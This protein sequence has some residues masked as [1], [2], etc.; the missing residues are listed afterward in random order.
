MLAW[1]PCAAADPNGPDVPA[2]PDGSGA[3]ASPAAPMAPGA[4]GPGADTPPA[5][6]PAGPNAGTLMLSDLGVNSTIKFNGKHN[7]RIATISFPVPKGLAPTSL[8]ATVELPIPMRWGSLTAAQSGRTISRVPLPVEDRGP[9]VIPLNGVDINGGW[10]TVTL[11]MIAD[12]SQDNYC[13]DPLS[14]ARLTNSSVTFSGT[15]LPPATVADF[16]TPGLR[17]LTIAVPPKPSGAES[18]AAVQLAAALSTRYGWQ[19]TD[20][21]VVPADGNGS[22]PD[23]APG[24]R[25]IILNER[26]DKG[27]ALQPKPGWPA[28]LITGQGDELTNQTRLLTDASL[29]YALSAKAVPGPLVTDQPLATDTITL[30][31]LS[32]GVVGTNSEIESL[33]PELTITID[34]TRWAQPLN[35]I[36]VHLIGSYTPM[37]VDFNGEIVA[38]IGND[39]IDRWAFNPEGSIDRWITIPNHLVN[40]SIDL[41]IREHA[42]GDPGNCD[43]FLNPQLRIDPQETEIQVNRASPPVP[44][45]FRSLPQALGPTVQIGIGPDKLADTIR[46]AKIMVGL[47]RTSAL[48]L[49]T[50]VVDLKEA[51]SGKESAVLISADGWKDKDLT[52]PF[53]TDMGK[54]TINALYESGE[55]ATMTLDPGIKTGSLQT[56]YDGQRSVLVATSNGAP[57]QLDEL[58]RWLNA[59]PGRWSGLD[60]RAIISTPFNAPVTVP[61]RKSDLPTDDGGGQHGKLGKDQAWWVAG[62][63][64]ALAFL[65][66]LAILLRTRKTRVAAG[67]QPAAQAGPS[68]EPGP[69]DLPVERYGDWSDEGP[70]DPYE[71]RPEDR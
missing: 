39:I 32:P 49:I 60:G 42:T 65:G 15:Q 20:I 6:A 47:Q 59:D 44:P 70:T 23:A 4:P 69:D 5:P 40:R 27:V 28:L 55:S 3:P 8:N 9:M 11:T 13:W 1:A 22:L 21:S 25:Q 51:L 16:L 43:D 50:N 7:T 18:N 14:P 53:N 66:A 45:G 57:E 37:P 19:S 62:A 56:I 33:Q 34:Q 41:N 67:D 26:P 52:L 36:K 29:P 61:N 24:E 35:G 54:V 31:D 17:K 68:T 10:A 71:R 46:A 12:P 58:L 30:A 63:F 38:E 2:V 64:G 48:P